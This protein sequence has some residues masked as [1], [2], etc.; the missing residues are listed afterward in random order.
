M[1]IIVKFALPLIAFVLLVATNAALYIGQLP[2]VREQCKTLEMSVFDN[3]TN[4]CIV[5]HKEVSRS[6]ICS[7][8]NNCSATLLYTAIYRQ[9]TI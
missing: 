6:A 5:A 2:N 3:E 1:S 7:H 9:F 8:S 4:T